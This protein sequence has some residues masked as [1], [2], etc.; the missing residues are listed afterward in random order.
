M[1]GGLG[2]GYCEH[3]ACELWFEHRSLG[4]AYKLM[5]YLNI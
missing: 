5:D 3:L 4:N 2:L 1:C